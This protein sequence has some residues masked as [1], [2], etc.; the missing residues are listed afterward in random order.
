[1]ESEEDP[2]IVKY[3][4]SSLEYD[5]LK[6]FETKCAELT[7]EIE[8]LKLSMS[9]QIGSGEC[10]VIL[11]DNNEIAKP[12]LKTVDNTENKA[13]NYSDIIKKNDDN[14]QFDE[15]ALLHLVPD[16][17]KRNAKLLLTKL[18][19][20]GTELTWNSSGLVYIDQ[21]SIPNSNFFLIFPHLFQKCFPNAKID[22]LL[23]VKNKLIFMGLFDLVK[24]QDTSDVIGG[25][26]MS[27]ENLV[28]RSEHNA[29]IEETMLEDSFPWYYIGTVR[30]LFPQILK[31][32]I[33]FFN[34]YFSLKY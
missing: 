8:Q 15:S 17:C 25:S 19:D 20:R 22:G 2:L 16:D 26:A 30:K 6:Y 4:V 7:K 21:T 12:L 27:I 23:E 9:E 18:N 31:N 5:K 24:L 1:M 13:I 34:F 11:D 10:V 29:E 32:I 14:D 28:S 3:L 33:Q